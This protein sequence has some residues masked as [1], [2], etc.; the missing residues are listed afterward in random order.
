MAA[1]DLGI[2]LS[3]GANSARGAFSEVNY[4]LLKQRVRATPCRVSDQPRVRAS[5]GVCRQ[6]I[7][8]LVGHTALHKCSAFFCQLAKVD[9]LVL[10]DFGITPLGDTVVRDLLETIAMAVARHSSPA[11]CRSTNGTPLSATAPSPTPS[12]TGLCTTPTSARCKA[13][14]CESALRQ[15][16]AGP[17]LA[18]PNVDQ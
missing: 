8:E 5:G 4:R 10:D 1:S 6:L 12:S 18:P 15:P 17:A 3:T 9:L 2:S 13:T 11:S 7:D 14:R 16:L